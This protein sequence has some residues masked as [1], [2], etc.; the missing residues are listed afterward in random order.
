MHCSCAPL[1]TL[2][3]TTRGILE[4]STHIRRF[5]SVSQDSSAWLQASAAECQHLRHNHPGN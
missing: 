3:C 2:T 5:V 4:F 1:N